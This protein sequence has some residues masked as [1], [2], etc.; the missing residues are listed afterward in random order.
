MK[1]CNAVHALNDL[2]DTTNFIEGGDWNVTI[3]SLDE[4]GGVPWKS[5]HRNKP[6]IKESNT[7]KS[8]AFLIIQRTESLLK[9]RH[10]SRCSLLL[11]LL[12]T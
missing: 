10:F 7:Y 11:Q 4:R 9:N 2:N 3:Q 12:L 8:C 5:T 1:L 6:I